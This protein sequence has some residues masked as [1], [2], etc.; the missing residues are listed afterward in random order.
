MNNLLLNITMFIHSLIEFFFTFYL[1]IFYYTKKYDIIYSIIMFIL[2]I[3]WNLFK[4]ECILSYI[5]K[6]LL[7]NNYKMGTN[8][9]YHPFKNIQNKYIRMIM[10][11]MKVITVIIVFIRNIKNIYIFL[12]LFIIMLNQFYHL[13]IKLKIK[14]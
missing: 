9:Y 7:D 2:F 12:M 1:V 10:D 11:F 4:G 5:E 3:H 6:K 14:I 8:V 13:Y